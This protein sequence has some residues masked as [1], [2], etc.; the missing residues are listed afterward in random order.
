[1]GGECIF[2]RIVAG[3]APATIVEE[4]ATAIVIVPLYPVVEGHLL[5]IP[6]AHMSDAAASPTLTG[7]MF[8][9]A[10][11]AAAK[12][13]E[14]FNLITSRGTP[15]TQSVFHLH[16]HI[17]PRERGDHLPL[18][19]SHPDTLAKRLAEIDPEERSWTRESRSG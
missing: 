7:N 18:P 9:L 4:F 2:C 10:S 6:K 1:M 12:R 8:A 17:V 14:S 19:W 11:I 15:A 16:V 13:Y 5:V 3:D